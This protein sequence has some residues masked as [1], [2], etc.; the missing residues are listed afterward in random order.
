MYKMVT[1]RMIQYWNDYHKKFC[2]WLSY[3][4]LAVIWVTGGT[5]IACFDED[6]METQYGY[7]RISTGKQNTERQERRRHGC[8]YQK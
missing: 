8:S 6:T 3:F 1:V 5:G 4:G 7:C 2:G